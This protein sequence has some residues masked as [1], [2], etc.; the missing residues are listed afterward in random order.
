MSGDID[1]RAKFVR[2]I[3][4]II[5]ERDFVHALGLLSTERQKD[6]NDTELLY[7][8]AVAARYAKHYGE[9]EG[10]LASLLKDSP[11]MGRAHQEVAH[12]ARDRGNGQA[13]LQAYRQA[14]ECN[15]ALIASWQALASAYSGLAKQHAADQVRY[16]SSLSP[17][18]LHAHQLL[19]EGR[20]AQAEDVCRAILTQQPQNIEA[21]KMLADIASRLGVLD[22][23]EFL[24]ESATTFAPEDDRL[25]FDYI[26]I[27]RKRQKF[28]EA[29]AQAERL[30]QRRPNDL[31]VI[32]QLA[33]EKMQLG[34][35]DEAIKFFDDILSKAPED[36]YTLTSRGHALKTVG[37]EGAAVESYQSAARSKP[38]H[39]DAYFSLSNLKTYR[40]DDNEV[41]NMRAQLQRNDLTLNNRIYFNFALASACEHFGQYDES[42]DYLNEGNLLKRKQSRY[43]ADQ[44]TD[45]MNAQIQY[46]DEAVMARKAGCDAP[47]PIFIVGLPR[48]GSTLIEQILASHSMVDGTLELPNILATAQSLRG[49][50]RITGESAY[51]E[52][53]K[54]LTDDKCKAL[55]EAFM[56]DTRIH[57]KGAPFFTDKMPN[58]FRHI[59]LI[60]LIL[61]N[62]KIIDARRN[63]LDCCF[64][65][66]KQL[67]AQGQEFTYGLAEI[68]RYYADYVRLME[69]WD[70]VLP[71]KILRV[72]HE[73]VL[74][75]TQG[76]V[77]RLLDYL[78]LPFEENCVRFHETKRAV[79][80]ASSE[81]VRRPI[82][83][84]GVGRWRPFIAH[85]QPLAKALGPD[86]IS[87]DDYKLIMEEKG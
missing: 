62:A 57:R 34:Q 22:E 36:P 3:Q 16:W 83:R 43:R 38:D 74:E 72:Q 5:Q 59:G 42:F 68:G 49:R 41:S 8:S 27:L 28:Q 46:C 32:S 20:L 9:A 30:A 25:R 47:D 50:Q 73:D 63:A 17:T 79:R 4:G 65:G 58:N 33:I 31:T 10:Y 55:G 56:E 48:A 15:P 2:T 78:G 53:L 77:H 23:A 26:L 12:L 29:Y 45:E 80:T 69:H 19:Y 13:A 35:H 82:N 1:E 24:L 67:F 11:D 37:D 71:G 54:T 64:S 85:L 61:P 86:L 14:V 84:D 87:T 81:Q 52:I 70:N 39:G 66:F 6:P 75:D 18:L 21:M 40:F 51:P 76:Q 60:H 7:L 44:M